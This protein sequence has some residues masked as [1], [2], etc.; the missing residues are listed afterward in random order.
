MALV[1]LWLEGFTNISEIASRDG[2]GC[3]NG[4]T[5]VP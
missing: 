5:A 3:I 4:S 2:N 1:A